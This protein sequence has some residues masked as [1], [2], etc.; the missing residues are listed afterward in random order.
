MG[1]QESDMTERLSTSISSVQF[2]QLCPTL[3]DPMSYSMPGLPVHH[4]LL[5][6]TQTH[7]QEQAYTGTLKGNVIMRYIWTSV[8][9]GLEW[10]L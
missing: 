10:L 6:P 9:E 4:Q 1:L 8:L 2:T 5:E 3:C 7:V